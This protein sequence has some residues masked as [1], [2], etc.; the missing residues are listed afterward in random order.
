MEHSPDTLQVDANSR[1]PAFGDLATQGRDKTLDILPGDIRA[2]GLFCDPIE[3]PLVLFV[4]SKDMV[5][6]TSIRS[7]PSVTSYTQHE[8]SLQQKKD[9]GRPGGIQG[10]PESAD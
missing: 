6:H 10:Q 5:S 3:C 7:R 2:L 1:T 4:H 8:S 9:P